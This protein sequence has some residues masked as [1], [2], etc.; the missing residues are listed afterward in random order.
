M[1]VSTTLVYGA[2]PKNPNFLAETS[3]LRGHRD[4]RFIN[5][6]VHAEKQA[7]R[8]AREHA[9]RRSRSCGSRRSWAQVEPTVEPR[10]PKR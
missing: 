9:R 2:N 8:F 7:L 10:A 6:K 1:M 5:D 4:S 3:E